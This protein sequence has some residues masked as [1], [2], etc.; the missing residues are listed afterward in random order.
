MPPSAR[1]THSTAPVR[2]SMIDRPDISKTLVVRKF[3][4]AVL[5]VSPQLPENTPTE[6]FNIKPVEIYFRFPPRPSKIQ[7]P[8]AKGTNPRK[9][10]PSTA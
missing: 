7:Y 1:H 8:H 9:Q 6:G 10:R 5:I 3:A 4:E 2:K